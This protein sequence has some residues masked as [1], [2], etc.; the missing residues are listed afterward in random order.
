M[1][2]VA[3]RKSFIIVAFLIIMFTF[4]AFFVIFSGNMPMAHAAS[5]SDLK[6]TLFNSGTEYRVSA[7]NKSLIEADI[8]EHYNGLPVTEIADNGFSNCFL[9]KKVRIPSTIRTVGTS[10][11]SGSTNLVR[12]VGMAGV[13][14]IKNMAFNNCTSLN[15]LI[16]PNPERLSSCG[17]SILRNVPNNVYL[18]GDEDTCIATLEDLNANALA[19]YDSSKIIRG[20][21]AD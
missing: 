4:S 11:F 1:K 19:G 7:L 18:R 2:K 20:V 15:N 14:A 13:T 6:F 8:P 12:L 10:A 5:I 9:L 16:I 21:V 3:T 17:A